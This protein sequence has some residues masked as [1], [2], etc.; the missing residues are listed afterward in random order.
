MGAI[1]CWRGCTNRMN[2][3]LSARR[4][5]S[6]EMGAARNVRKPHA[7]SSGVFD[8]SV[9]SLDSAAAVSESEK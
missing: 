5:S 6:E 7:K 4:V 2:L 3:C 1:T 8:L 9:T